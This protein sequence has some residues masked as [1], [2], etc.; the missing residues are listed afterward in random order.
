MRL[1]PF[2]PILPALVTL[3]LLAPGRQA[4]AGLPPDNGWHLAKD[5]DHIKI[6][7][8]DM[9]GSDFEAFKAVAVLNAPLAN[10]MAVM[11][12]PSSCM[13]WVHGCIAAENIKVESFNQRYAYS[14]N[15][16]PWPVSNRD[17]VLRINTGANPDT[18]EI[19]MRFHA[20]SGMKPPTPDNVR[21]T[22]SDTLY[23]F[24]AVDAT[25]T[26]MTWIQHTD[27]NGMLPGWLV[28]T[29][30]V[31]IP[32]DSLKKLGKVANLPQ[33]QGYHIHYDKDGQITGVDKLA[34]DP[35]ISDDAGSS[36]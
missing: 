18:G 15:D 22:D 16:L 4:L 3:L 31:D 29:L 28:N 17:Y 11:V 33:Y 26:R 34:K 6:Y 12:T 9:P 7:T 1:P 2:R 20:V 5:Q 13:Q 27:P 8:R 23:R 32:F 35:L 21:V 25:H 14:V 24:K 19:I 36:H 10:V 30:A